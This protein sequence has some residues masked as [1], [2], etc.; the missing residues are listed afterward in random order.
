M[1]LNIKKVII[2]ILILLLVI[3]GIWAGISLTKTTSNENIE[4]ESYNTNTNSNNLIEKIKYKLFDI[5]NSP[6]LIK[7]EKYNGKDCY[8]IVENFGFNIS[9]TIRYIEK[10]TFLPVATI[11]NLNNQKEEYNCQIREITDEEIDLPNLSNYYVMVN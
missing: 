6:I 3:I 8:K 11:D 9:A 5:A 7:S 4:Q 1:K 10:E 2:V